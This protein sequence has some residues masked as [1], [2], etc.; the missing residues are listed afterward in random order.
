VDVEMFLLIVLW[1]IFFAFSF[2]IAGVIFVLM[3]R[4][5]KK[6]WKIKMDEN[7]KPK[8]S[9]LIPT[10][11]EA[12]I[13]RFKL[14]NLIKV[15]YPKDLMQ[16]IVVDS[17][18]EDQTLSVV[19]Q[20]IKQHPEWSIQILTESERKGKSAALNFALKKCEGEVIIISDADCFWPQDILGKAL[21]FLAD[22]T[23]GAISGPK[24]LLNP[25]QSW[26]T[27]TENV[28]VNLHNQVKLGELKIHSTVFFEGGFGAYKKEFL[29]SF[30]PYNTG[31]DDSGTVV[32]ILERNL[33]AIL[34]PEA[35]FYSAFPLI[36]KEK[37]GIKMRR[38]NQLV[39]VFIRY[40]ILLLNRRIKNS[41]FVILQNTFLY[42]ISPLAFIIFLAITIMM[43]LSFPYFGLVF[44]VLLV[45]KVRSYLFEITQNYFILFLTIFSI[46]F[47]KKITFWSKSKDRALLT[48]G[49]L[50]KYMLI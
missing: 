3:K 4:A 42:L 40:V 7:Y 27:E 46:I 48:E 29:E 24:I 49:I 21:P 37:I 33:R 12:D 2:G 26:V 34:V 32:K 47:G 20:F 22:P 50:R 14:E 17:N 10:Y 23:V 16:V 13:I 8:I 15:K 18:S 39:R 36:W 1:L 38:A 41:K 6:P 44:V 31:S 5:A 35:K 19:N 25:T 43:L 30:D 9:I 45:P 28:Y 11:N